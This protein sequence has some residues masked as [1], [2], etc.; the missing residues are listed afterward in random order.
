M[1]FVADLGPAMSKVSI[2]VMTEFGRTLAQNANGGTDHGNASAWFALG[3]A[4]RG[5]IYLG[6]RGWP[7]LLPDQLREARDLAHSVEFRQ[8]MSNLLTR[9]LALPA[10]LVPSVL[11]G[12]A[13]SPL[14]FI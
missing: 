4:V 9:H 1:A 12:A 7:G 11:P 6:P 10:A 14:G 5:G 2:L 13:T 8:V 3:G